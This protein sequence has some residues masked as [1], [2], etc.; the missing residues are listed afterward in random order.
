MLETIEGQIQATIEFRW[1]H[2]NNGCSERKNRPFVIR[3]MSAVGRTNEEAIQYTHVLA[4]QHAEICDECQ[5]DYVF[6]GVQ[7]QLT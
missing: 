2:P 5:E 3:S 1:E 7:S 4:E 6:K